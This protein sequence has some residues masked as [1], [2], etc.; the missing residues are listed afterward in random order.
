MMRQNLMMLA[1]AVALAPACTKR[2]AHR[3]EPADP[4]DEA[5][6]RK[7]AD[8]EI[9]KMLKSTVLHF[10][11]DDASLTTAD[12]TMLQKVAEALRTR[13][14]IAIRIG[15]HTDE[16]GTE[17]YNLAL[18]QRRADAARGYLQALGVPDNQIETVSFGEEA[19]AVAASTEEAWASNRRDE[20]GVLPL[21][22]FTYADHQEELK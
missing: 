22:L 18:G 1:V 6:Q 7:V 15:G 9:E 19:P 2:I 10:G 12:Q 14:W 16:R 3:Y 21:D 17:E 5:S 13:P 11:F 20:L 8:V 4:T